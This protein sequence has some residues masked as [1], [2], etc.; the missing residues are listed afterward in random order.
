[1]VIT[2]NVFILCQIVNYINYLNLRYD[3]RL[4]S[5]LALILQLVD[6]YINDG[7]SLWC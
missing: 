2:Y 5:A 4:M 6:Y 7:F 1:M 3:I